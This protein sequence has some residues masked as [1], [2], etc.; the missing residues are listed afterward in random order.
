[1]TY[2]K[3]WPG[4]RVV[5][6]GFHVERGGLV[7]AIGVDGT[8]H[9]ACERGYLPVRIMSGGRWTSSLYMSKCNAVLG[10]VGCQIRYTDVEP[11]TPAARAFLRAVT[12]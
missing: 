7:E 2:P 11:L 6:G 4:F 10:Y 5:A 3:E 1:M 8:A 12:K 9:G